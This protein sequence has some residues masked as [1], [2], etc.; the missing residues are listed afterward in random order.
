[1]AGQPGT[2]PG[3]SRTQEAAGRPPAVSVPGKISAADVCLAVAIGLCVLAVHDVGYILSTSYWNDES[4][5]AA[6]VRA[7]V[8]LLPSMAQS[9]PL[10]WTFLLRLVPFGGP[11]RL[12]LV[13]LGF[14]GLAA[15][16]GYFFG[17]ELGLGRYSTGILTGAAA[18]LV[19]AMLVRNDLKQYTAE[20][21]ACLL[22]WVLVARAENRWSRRR[23]VAIAATASLGML[24][25]DTVIVVGVAGMAGLAIECLIR[26]QYRR[27]AEVGAA[28]A[29]MLAV[30]LVIYEVLIRPQDTPGLQAFWAPFYVPTRS[31]SASASFVILRFHALAALMGFPLPAVDAVGVLAGIVALLWLRRYALAVMFPIMLAIVIVASAARKYPFGDLRTSTFWLVLVPVLV[32]V[33]VAAAGRLSTALDSRMPVVIAAAAVLILLPVARP[34]LRNHS[35]PPGEDVHSEVTYLD[36]HFRRGDIVIVNYGASFGF[37]Y[38]YPAQPSFPA[39]HGTANPHVV[40]Y[41]RLPWMIMMTG[42]R[43]VDVAAAL[44]KARAKI[45]AEPASARG[46]IWIVRSHTSATEYQ[47]WERDLAGKRAAAIRVGPEPI[48]LY[49]P[50][51]AGPAGCT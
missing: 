47:A 48:L 32:M 18:L 2:A 28:S 22:V 42:G 43:P 30:A 38:Y 6:T 8:A 19:P 46:R 33:G 25:A 1:M 21:F 26:R 23:L 5:V 4:W 49:T 11:E 31:L 29:G 27:L 40:A 3:I 17:R 13:P 15:A 7:P 24:F 10:G 51:C 34:Y 45:A 9:T 14:A 36:S 50:S 16:A 41:P 37:A 20:A 35:L 44:A 12:R 39:G